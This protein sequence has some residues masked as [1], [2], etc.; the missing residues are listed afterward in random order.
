[1]ANNSNL[2]NSDLLLDYIKKNE[3]VILDLLE[4]L[5]LAS[6]DERLIKLNRYIKRHFD[7]HK[8][9]VRLL[10]EEDEAFKVSL[11]SDVFVA[12]WPEKKQAATDPETT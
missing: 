1:M 6:E 9:Y 8:R 3:G 12:L 5:V 4:P 10:Q 2:Y 11:L 7:L